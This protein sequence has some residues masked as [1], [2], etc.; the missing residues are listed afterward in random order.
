[1]SVFGWWV[2]SILPGG[3]RVLRKGEKK[4]NI[5]VRKGDGLFGKK[6]ESDFIFCST[7]KKPKK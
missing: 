3:K 1:M 7:K 6:K 4:I 2:T 5:E